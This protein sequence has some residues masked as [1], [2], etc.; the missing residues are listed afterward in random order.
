MYSGD[1]FS[2]RETPHVFK[3][4]ISWHRRQRPGE[5]RKWNARGWMGGRRQYERAALYCPHCRTKA[6]VESQ[7]CTELPDLIVEA[8]RFG[9]MHAI[10][11]VA[12]R[13]TARQ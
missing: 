1:P 2:L 5:Q 7:A 4:L 9:K 12:T 6:K 8:V 10:G 11:G 3:V 13:H